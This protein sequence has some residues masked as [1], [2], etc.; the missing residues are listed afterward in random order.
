MQEIPRVARNR[1]R[2]LIQQDVI[3]RDR[4]ERS[5]LIQQDVI[6]RDRR[7]RSNLIQQDVIARDRRERSNLIL[8]TLGLPRF[9]RNDGNVGV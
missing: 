1:L 9:T 8:S 6:A 5:S 7:E 4:R 2:N 3:A